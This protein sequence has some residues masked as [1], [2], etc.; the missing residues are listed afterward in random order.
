MVFP[1]PVDRSGCRGGVSLFPVPNHSLGWR[2]RR[3]PVMLPVPTLCPSLL[4]GSLPPSGLFPCQGTEFMA[5]N[6]SRL[7]ECQAVI[8]SLWVALDQRRSERAQRR[9]GR[10]RAD[11]LA[12]GS[13]G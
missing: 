1:N 2:R 5:R 8:V 13:L 6:S 11:F 9:R 3:R 4:P 7:P 12:M 10:F